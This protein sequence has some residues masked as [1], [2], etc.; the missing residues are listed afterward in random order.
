MTTDEQE[1]DLRHRKVRDAMAETGLDLLLAFGPG[2]RRENVRY[3]SDARVTGSAAFVALPATGE[4]S[5]YS[6]RRQDVAEIAGRGWVTDAHFL[7][8][9]EPGEFRTRL[10]DSRARRIGIAHYELLPSMLLDLVREALPAAEIVSATALLDQARL[11]KSEWELARMRRSAKVCAAGW[12][13]FVDVL[14][15]GLPEYRVV[16]AV[17]AE[18]KRL[19]A[20]D[21]F[22]LIAS[23]KDEVR[24]MTPPSDRRLEDGDMVRTELTPQMDGYWLQICRSAVV[25][26]A[27]DAQK[28]SFDLFNEAV[29]AGMAVVKPGVTAH[30]VAVAQNDVFRRHGYG[31]YCTSQYTRVRGH[32]HGLHMD[33]TPII[34][35][36]HTV[37]PENSVFIIHPNTYTPIAG[38]HVLGDPVRVTADGCEVLVETERKLF[39]T[40]E[41]NA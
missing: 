30:E 14:E 13:A 2:W 5:A 8:P 9:A 11:V 33:E 23:G 27:S 24:G 1:R 7:D 34:E 40:N 22:M 26:T 41:V 35:G 39:Q 19:G 31:E 20:E 3:L 15:P 4:A 38:Y 25:G 21:N 28:R 16:A 18:I 29:D 37:L 17:E 32:G 10:G 12:Q 6:T 36:N